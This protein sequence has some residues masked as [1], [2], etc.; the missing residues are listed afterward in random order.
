MTSVAPL[1]EMVD[2]RGGVRPRWRNLLG[3]LT[4]LGHETLLERRARLDRA[5]E[6]EGVGS[7][8]PGA[9]TASPRCDPVPLLLSEGEFADLSAGLAQRARLLELILADIYGPQTLL[10]NGALPPALAF[11]NPRFLRPCRGQPC[12]DRACA[13]TPLTLCA[14]RTGRGASSPTTPAGPKAPRAR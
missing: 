1:D 5:F 3:A 10:A 13:S 2:G 7:L 4:E 11:A 14:A 9:E 6:E 8:L 12:R